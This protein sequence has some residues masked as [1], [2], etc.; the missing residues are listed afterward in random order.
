MAKRTASARCDGCGAEWAITYDGETP[1]HAATAQ[2]AVDLAAK[3]HVCSA[4]PRKRVY[5]EGGGDIEKP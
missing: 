3:Q 1:E 4:K 5:R 2:R